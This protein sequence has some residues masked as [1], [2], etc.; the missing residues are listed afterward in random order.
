MEYKFNSLQ[1]E[2][3]DD[4]LKDLD[5]SSI[6]EL[7]DCLNKIY[8]IQALTRPDRKYAK[9]LQ[10]WY[11]PNILDSRIEDKNGRI[12]VDLEN[13]HILED[14]DYFRPAA[15][16]FEEFGCYTKLFCNL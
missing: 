9:D 6:S 16:H 1:T 2:L 8:L 11:N 10:R 14:M 4:V 5:S 7:Y 12:Y 13:P 3:T 15:K